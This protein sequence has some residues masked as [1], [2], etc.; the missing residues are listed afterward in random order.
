MTSVTESVEVA[1]PVRTAYNQWTQFEEFPE[2]MAGV[3]EVRQ[4]SDRTTHWRTKIAGVEREFDAE[5]VEQVPDQRVAWMAQGVTHAGEVTFE[6]LGADRTRVTAKMDFEPEGAVE[7]VGDKLG[8]VDH[9]VKAD[10]ARF[11]EYIEKRGAAS[12]A[13][14]GE[15]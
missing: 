3:E 7:Q 1:V 12:G 11:K 4:L 14:R 5:I 10:M 2:F 15:I 6:P 9:R 8:M 13:W